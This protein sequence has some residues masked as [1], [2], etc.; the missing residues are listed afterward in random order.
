MGADSKP[1]LDITG[2]VALEDAIIR[3][4]RIRSTGLDPD[5]PDEVLAFERRENMS[6]TERFLAM[7]TLWRLL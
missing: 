3:R 2:S 5:N 6:P 1:S 4:E 7:M